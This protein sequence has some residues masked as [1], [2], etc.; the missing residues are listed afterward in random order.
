M[1][2]KPQ[3]PQQQQQQQQQAPELV[4]PVPYKVTTPKGIVN[5]KAHNVSVSAGC[6]IF[7]R[8]VHATADGQGVINVA[9]LILAPGEWLR[10]ESDYEGTSVHIARVAL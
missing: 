10:S 6:L 5:V 8:G 1:F 9:P 3:P 2:D 7:V 4:Q